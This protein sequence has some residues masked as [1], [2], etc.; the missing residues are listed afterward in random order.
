MKL[1]NHEVDPYTCIFLPF[2]APAQDEDGSVQPRKG[3]LKPGSLSRSG[4]QTKPRKGQSHPQR[5]LEDEDDD[6]SGS[7]LD[8]DVSE[9]FADDD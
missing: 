9:S 6:G 8:F 2:T 3:F 7:D 1:T 4:S 5:D